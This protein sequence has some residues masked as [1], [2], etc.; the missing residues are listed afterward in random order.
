[1]EWLNQL[2]R[3]VLML[4]RRNQFDRDLDEEMRL[5]LE[6]REKEQREAGL[7]PEE[8][9]YAARRQFGNATLLKEVSREMWGWNSLEQLIQD[10]RYGA[11]QLRLSPGFT[12]VAILSLALGIGANTAIFQ[13]LDAVRLRSLPIPNPQE[14]ADVRI[15]GGNG[16]MGVNNGTYPQLTRPI[17]QVL[18]EHH[19]PFSGVFAWGDGG[20]NIGQGS[21]TRWRHAIWVSGEFFRVLD[22]SPWRG[23]MIL[24]EDEGRCPASRAVVSYS[25][26]QGEMGGRELGA[27]STLLIDGDLVE[28]VGV[29]PPQFFGL[30]VGDNFDIAI[31]FCQPKEPLRR[32]VF[33]IAVMGRLRPGWT[34]KRAS[35]ELEAASPGILEATALTGRSARAIETYKHFRLAAYPASTGVSQLRDQSEASLWLLLA[36]TGLVLLIACTNLAN[37]MLARASTREREMAVRLALGAS[38]R[39]LLRQLLAESVLL[40]AI[41]AALGVGLAGALSRVLVWSVST[42]G[43]TVYLPLATDWRV[44]LFAATVAGLTCVVF[45]AVPALRASRAEPMAAMKSGGRGVTGGRERFTL[46]CFLVTTQIAVSLVLLVGAFLF[47]RSFR[48]L[49][50]FDPGMREAGITVAVVAFQQSHVSPDR[51][52]EFKRQLLEEVR[53]TPGIL[54]AATTTNMPL[55]GGSWE[56][57]IHI[58]S[59]E[60]TSKFTWVS[61]GYFQTMG[62]PLVMGR[63]FNQDDTGTSQRVAVVNRTF[64]RRFLGGANPIGKTLRTEPEPDY[65]ST[66]YEIVGVIPDTQYNS[67]R[68]QTPPMTFA[69]ASQY[70]ADGPWTFMPIHSNLDPATVASTVKRKIAERHP[71]IVTTAGDFQT[72]I[73]NGLVA[74]RLMAMLSGFFGLLAALLAMVGLYGMITYTVA[75]RRNEIGIRMALGAQPAQVVSMVVQEAGRLLVIGVAAGTVLSLV[76]GRGAGALLFGLKPYDPLTLLAAS[77]LL[78]AIAALASFVP[79]R[80]ASKVDPM[81]ALRYE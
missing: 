44:L 30:A 33:D 62:I 1:M 38:R 16:G 72:W 76:A 17:W 43:N 20:V 19:E 25:Y 3:R 60:G 46:Q 69:P 12:T 48:N 61:P 53:A 47:V 55:L 9:H 24:P 57:G 23:R 10:L 70:P 59:S 45:G 4:L 63:D 31:P 67:L 40:A 79:A 13:L 73:R 65:P 36:I 34:V 42:E 5:H 75:R 56:H 54:S 78:A 71:E 18:R 8:A 68:D 81:V 26:W 80:R 2:G 52:A 6:L 21:E 35:A 49:I 28:I 27:G 74:E 32:D 22:V 51:Y 58:G 64:V 66:V 37:L 39:R 41:G 77:A 14:L 50:T 29:T 15:V 11:R 7:Q